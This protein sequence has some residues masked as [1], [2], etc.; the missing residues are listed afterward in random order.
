MYIPKISLIVPCYKAGEFIKKAIDNK[1]RVLE[2]L[3]ISYE[4]IIV[5]DGS[6]EDARIELKNFK[7]NKNI[8]IVLLKKNHGKGYAVRRGMQQ[9]KGEYI[10]YMDV[11]ND[12]EPNVIKD[13]YERIIERDYNAVLPSK[14][15]PDSKIKYPVNRKIFSRIYNFIVRDIFK[16]NCFDTQLGAKLYTNKLI[17]TTLP[18][19]VINGF[20]FEL[21]ILGV[22]KKL[23]ILNMVEIPVTVNF[24]TQ[25]TIS[26][27]SGIKVLSDTFKLFLRLKKIEAK[28]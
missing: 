22:A 27:K 26:L 7:N 12:I 17:K 13:M 3:G 9:A 1:I 11:D 10:G 18:Y 16:L 24:K 8:K 15:H 2:G 5:Q 4:L 19:C 23:E 25:T 21:E 14:M 6:D 20:A 28:K